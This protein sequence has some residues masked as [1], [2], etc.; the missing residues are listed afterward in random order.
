MDK[1]QVTNY[2]DSSKKNFENEISFREECD[3]PAR[4]KK[5][6]PTKAQKKKIEEKNSRR[7]SSSSV[8]RL[9]IGVGKELPPALFKEEIPPLSFPPKILSPVGGN[10]RKITAEDRPCACPIARQKSLAD[11]GGKPPPLPLF[12]PFL[13]MPVCTLVGDRSRQILLRKK[14]LFCRFSLIFDAGGH[15][16]LPV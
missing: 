4:V 15:R 9:P 7:E 16:R 3:G 10:R 13:P 5:S 6:Q 12:S 2:E 8:H 11:I 1:I 14:T